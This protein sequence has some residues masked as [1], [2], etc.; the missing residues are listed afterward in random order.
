M[1]RAYAARVGRREEGKKKRKKNIIL[2]YIIYNSISFLLVTFLFSN[3]SLDYFF[4]QTTIIKVALRV[5]LMIIS[6]NLSVP[7]KIKFS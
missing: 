1:R 3:G 4:S 5:R 2:Y 7:P 6:L